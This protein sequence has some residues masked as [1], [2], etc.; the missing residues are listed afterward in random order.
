MGKLKCEISVK[1]ISR[2]A[3]DFPLP[4]L[5]CLFAKS[6]DFWIYFPKFWFEVIIIPSAMAKGILYLLYDAMLL[7]WV[8]KKLEFASIIYP[9]TKIHS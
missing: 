7:I 1:Y 6:K 8:S 2:N 9:F 5:Q 3:L 4:F